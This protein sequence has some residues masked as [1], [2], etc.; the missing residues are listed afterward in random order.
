LRALNAV[1]LIAT[2]ELGRPESFATLVEKRPL[3]AVLHVAYRRDAGSEGHGAAM[4]SGV[5]SLSVRPGAR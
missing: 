3:R 2:L 5:P 4:A 1:F